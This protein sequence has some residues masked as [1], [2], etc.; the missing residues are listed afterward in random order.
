M[1][2]KQKKIWLLIALISVI[3][4]TICGFLLCNK[5][6]KEC[7]VVY[8][9]GYAADIK[10]PKAQTVKK[11]EVIHCPEDPTRD[12]FVF[13]GWYT[14]NCTSHPYDFNTPVNHSFSLTAKWADLNDTKDTDGDGL[15]DA[16]E[17]TIGT[18]INVIDTDGDSLSDY[19]EFVVLGLDPLKKDTD[20]NGIFDG[21]EDS[22]GDGLSNAEEEMLW[23]SPLFS[24]TDSDGLTDFDEYSEYK[25]APIN[26]D[27]DHDGVND[28]REIQSGSDPLKYD[29]VFLT[30]K[31]SGAISE[32]YPIEAYVIAE[33]DAAGAGSLSITPIT[34]TNIP[35]L[36]EVSEGYLGTAFELHTDGKLSK[37]TIE[38]S[39]DTSL[40]TLGDDFE[41]R[42]YFYDEAEN[43]LIELENQVVTEGKVTAETSHFSA[44][45]LLNKMIVDM[46]KIINLPDNSSYDSNN[47]GISD[48]YTELI[49]NG[50]LLYDNTY[51][52]VGVLDLYGNQSD[53]WDG[54]GLKNGEEISIGK[55]FFGFLKI[56]IKSNPILVDSDF[57]GLSDLVEVKQT[58][59]DPLRYN[60]RS[61]AALNDLQR[62]DLYLYAREETDWM[63]DVMAIAN[64]ASTFFTYTKYDRA[65]E[66]LVNYFYEYAPEETIKKNAELIEWQE[67]Y[68]EVLKVY[69]S[70]S[71]M[72]KIAKDACEVLESGIKNAELENSYFESLTVRQNLL[73][74]INYKKA[75][76][77]TAY[78]ELKLLS[79][80]II[81]QDT[82]D[83][84]ISDDFYKRSKEVTNITDAATKAIAAYNSVCELHIYSL[85]REFNTYISTS[86]MLSG[87][88]D[89]SLISTNLSVICDIV[90]AEEDL[91]EVRG[92]YG[93]L[94]ANADAY[95]MY[96]ELLLYIKK[97]AKDVS[98]AS[99]AGD[100]AKMILDKSG[101]EY[102][103]QLAVA[104]GK[105]MT[106]S[107]AKASLDNVSKESIHVAIAK[108]L[109]D[110]YNFVT[111]SHVKYNV[112]FEVMKE[113]SNACNA[114]L[115]S[116]IE[117]QA[118]VF[119]YDVEDGAWVEKYLVQLAQSRL[120]GEY[121]FYEYVADEGLVAVLSNIVKVISADEFRKMYPNIAKTIYGY[122]N[123]L[124]LQLSENLPYFKEYWSDI[125]P[126][127]EITLPG[128]KIIATHVEPNEQAIFGI[129]QK[130]LEN[131]RKEILS[132]TWQ[133]KSRTP[134][135][136]TFYDI[137]GDGLP[138]MI[139]VSGLYQP[140]YGY[141]EI[142][143]STLHVLSYHD[144]YISEILNTGWD[145]LV[146]GG[147]YYILFA[148]KNESHLY[149]YIG[150]GDEW[151]KSGFCSAEHT[152]INTLTFRDRVYYINEPNW[153][154][155]VYYVGD[156]E[157]DEDTYNDKLAEMEDSIGEILMT[158]SVEYWDKALSLTYSEALDYA[159][160]I[161]GTNNNGDLSAYSFS[162]VYEEHDDEYVFSV[163]TDCP[164]D[165][166]TTVEWEWNM[167][168]L[169]IN[170]PD[171][172]WTIWIEN[173]KL[174]LKPIKMTWEI[175]L[176]LK[177]IYKNASGTATTM[178]TFFFVE[179]QGD[180]IP[181]IME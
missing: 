127:D 18:D 53:D 22:D 94:R 4:M 164:D 50:T 12:A 87:K 150:E 181:F 35:A 123:R 19:T 84:L 77:V 28:G 38:F 139:Y 104:C 63:D 163:N 20:E 16:I 145:S 3:I 10:A 44:Y 155:P 83:G 91:L 32:A 14:D 110:S 134:R 167:D 64:S 141:S 52:L 81:L 72:A 27:T 47:D 173:E 71:N 129:Y 70:I 171:S 66:V 146:G 175:E 143:N 132:Y 179:K 51:N 126:E 24:D 178:L 5:S 92:M 62:N 33:T 9:L 108:L 7:K 148:D 23:S 30:A 57:D 61:L 168:S 135:P 113:I 177:A 89:S 60:R 169:T 56:K 93:R 161:A 55:D 88:T 101:C 156:K 41:P 8:D 172:Y 121:Y 130:V 54:D 116:K 80:P 109:V 131:N 46:H 96:S 98:V 49:N 102:F 26:A 6:N 65:K 85:T 13:I 176:H 103:S 137:T 37:A 2:A 140:E 31:G 158:N 144:G 147:L 165:N 180:F 17:K 82:A 105:K 36:S 100:V 111:E 151:V 149:A 124:K 125:I 174:H 95:N 115:N 76:E 128:G 136:I 48:F 90:D 21:D 34:S 67:N 112:Y 142:L 153:D 122:A 75:T 1:K 79:L 119:S 159:I 25:T 106:F 15:Y 117:K 58:K 114:L 86:K 39:Y 157:V 59:T 69:G 107:V 74:D 162:I 68:E 45:I 160:S 40:G 42:I 170:D 29:E 11:G 43:E 99:A 154:N 73:S 138:E 166:T 152:E 120:M 78:K 97:N 133:H 118:E